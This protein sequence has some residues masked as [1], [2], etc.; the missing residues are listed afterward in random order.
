MIMSA[1]VTGSRMERSLLTSTP[2]IPAK[3]LILLVQN[4]DSMDMYK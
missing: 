3:M 1:H 4:V 2:L